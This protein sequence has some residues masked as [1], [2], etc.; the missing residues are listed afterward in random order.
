MKRV[1]LRRAVNRSSDG[2]SLGSRKFSSYYCTYL[3]LRRAV[4][5]RWNRFLEQYILMRNS[6]AT[7][8]EN[9]R[10]I[11]TPGRVFVRRLCFIDGGGWPSVRRFAACITHGG[12]TYLARLVSQQCAARRTLA[13][14]G[15]TLSGVTQK[16]W[17][18]V[19]ASCCSAWTAPPQ[20]AR[21]KGVGAPPTLDTRIVS[22]PLAH[23]FQD[24]GGFPGGRRR[25]PQ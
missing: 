18:E 11:M 3:S 19:F 6:I 22:R 8:R 14:N 25:A 5:R 24:V 2:E 15:I 12:D 13:S 23:K 20:P 10:T 21:P 4:Y 1:S 9:S 16:T 17:R 7:V